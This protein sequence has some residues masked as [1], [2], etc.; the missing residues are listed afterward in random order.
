V[1]DPIEAFCYWGVF[2]LGRYWFAGVAAYADAGV[3]FDFAQDW[4]AVFAGGL[5]AFAVAEDVDG[6]VA[7]GAREGAHVFDYAQDFYVYLAEHFDG[8][9]D[10]C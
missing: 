7:M 5:G 2:A 6:L 4:D 3:N 8:F 1:C 10:I 9:A